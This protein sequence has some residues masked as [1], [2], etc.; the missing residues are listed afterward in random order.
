MHKVNFFIIGA[1]KCGTTSLKSYLGEH[2]NIFMPKWKHEPK[3][4]A[5]KDMDFLYNGYGDETLRAANKLSD[6]LEL[7]KDVRNEKAI[8][9]KSTLY[10]YS[11]KAITNIKEEVEN[12]KFIA[13]FRQPADRAF[14]SF[15]HQWESGREKI[16][17]FQEALGQEAKRIKDNWWILWH[18][19]ECGMYYK[20]IK[21][22]FNAFDKNQIFICFYDDLVS[23]DMEFFSEIYSFLEVD[24]NYKPDVSTWL[25]KSKTEKRLYVNHG[26][27]SE[28][29]AE[30][31]L[32]FSEDVKR[33]ED[34]TKRDLSH[35]NCY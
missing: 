3:Y 19:V 26:F 1:G 28:F 21:K 6:Y 7:F 22:Y 24:K 8:G 12:P 14:S 11:E 5:L 25:N 13:I 4:F 16:E 30:L 31:S 2:L 29:R 34:L 17:N 18:Y 10:L 15:L 35:W 27:C 20:Y 23:G 32:K 9:E 33:L